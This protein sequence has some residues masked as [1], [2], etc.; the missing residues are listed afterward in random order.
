M[1]ISEQRSIQYFRTWRGKQGK[2]REVMANLERM[3]EFG[4]HLKSTIKPTLENRWKR[5]KTLKQ[6]LYKHVHG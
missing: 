6:T 3:K 1:E 4:S 5:C 2:E